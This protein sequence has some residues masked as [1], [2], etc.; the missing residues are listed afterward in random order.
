MVVILIFSGCTHHGNHGG[1]HS[2][3]D[4]YPYNSYR[5]SYG[6]HHHVPCRGY[7]PDGDCRVW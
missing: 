6:H 4:Y 7:G 2:G 5:S 3:Y 1:Y